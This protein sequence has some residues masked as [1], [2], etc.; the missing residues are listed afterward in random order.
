MAL[1]AQAFQVAGM[2]MRQGMK[3]V[4]GGL[5]VGVLAALGAGQL[6]SSFLFGV[7]ARDPATISVVAVLLAVVAAVACWIPARPRFADRA[8]DRLALRVGRPAIIRRLRSSKAKPFF[9]IPATGPS[10]IHPPP[11]YRW[12]RNHACPKTSDS[13]RRE[14]CERME[15]RRKRSQEIQRRCTGYPCSEGRACQ[16][17]RCSIIWKGAT[18]W[19][20]SSKDSQQSPAL[21]HWMRLKKPGNSSW[22]AF[23]AASDRRAHTPPST[24]A[25]VPSGLL[26]FFLPPAFNTVPRILCS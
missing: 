16:F 12:S 26:R 13:L 20:T 5:V 18:R 22:R 6:L 3:P 15:T 14:A 17:R 11:C 19:K 8:H 10:A 1:G 9:L 7:G 21:R 24:R 23:D 25:P 2:V 4:L